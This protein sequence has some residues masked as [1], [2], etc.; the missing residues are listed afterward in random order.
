MAL[1]SKKEL[2]YLKDRSYL[3][4]CLEKG[5]VDNW[6]FYSEAIE[7]YRKREEKKEKTESL[8]VEICEILSEDVEIDPAGIGTGISFH[9]DSIEELKQ[10]VFKKLI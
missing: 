10:L 8:V 3:L 9:P 1:I 5:G 7:D 4:D 6:E 2:D